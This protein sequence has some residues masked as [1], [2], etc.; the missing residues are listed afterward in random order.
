M[1]E[2]AV[3]LALA[4]LPSDFEM[5]EIEVPNNIKVNKL[6]LEE[7][8]ENW[9]I[10]PPILSTQK[11]GDKFIDSSDSCILKVPSA[12]VQG[13]YDYLINSHHPEFNEIKIIDVVIFPFDKRIFK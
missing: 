9:N 11:I 10:N 13:D 3:H 1:A 6:N 4:T 12:V 8:N 7:L 5:I 2:V